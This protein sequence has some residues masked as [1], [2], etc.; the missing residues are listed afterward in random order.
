M[1]A[2]TS[3]LTDDQRAVLAL[4]YE[5]NASLSAY[6]KLITSF[7][8][9]ELAWQAKVEAWRQLG[10]HHT[11]LK[12]HEQPEQTQANIDKIQQALIDSRYGLLFADQPDY[13]AQLLQIYDPPPLLFY[14]GNSARLYQAQIAIVGSR[15]PTAHAQKI[16]FD[17][18]QYL[19]QAGYIITSGLAMGVDK[20]AHLG[21]LAQT[22]TDYHGRTIGVMGTGID[23][24]YPN[25]HDQLFAQIIDQGGCIISELLPHTQPHKH[26]FPRRN[27]LVAGLSLA[28][29][30]TEATIKS[31]SLITA[32]L[33]SEQ[34]KQVFAIPSH[35]DNTNAEGCHHL[36][37]EGATLIYHPQQVLEDVNG[38]LTYDRHSYT[39][40]D[41]PQSNNSPS[42]QNIEAEKGAVTT[43]GH[44]TS[45]PSNIK[46]PASAIVVP[47]HLTPVYEQLDWH[48]QDLDA[49]I[50]ATA[51][52]P[53]QLIGQLM[54]LELLGVI[55]VQGGRY[56]RV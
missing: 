3:S 19:A 46:S 10:I 39:P 31:G 1:T 41:I 9:A 35:I 5:V 15:K 51:L 8:N 4:W 34:G 18:A 33:T 54:E 11:H 6:H 47:E 45:S 29:I 56:L 37:R 42:Q 25:H 30:V 7:G 49:L 48:G 26:T 36:I 28:T 22:D 44:A 32:R 12:R 43:D 53:P 2:V 17:I 24:N 20:R 50:V 38:Q 21:A 14:R 23:V 13:P 40:A 52:A 16:T 55:S 27:R